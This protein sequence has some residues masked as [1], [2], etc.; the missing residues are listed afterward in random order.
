MEIRLL[1]VPY[2]SGQRNVRMGAGPEHLRAAGLP[3][4]LA[5]SGHAVDVQM[6]EP[7]SMKWQAEVQ[8][9]F[10]LM[11]AVAEQVRA[12]RAEGRFPI[13]LSGNCLAAVG[14]IA[15]LGAPHRCDLDR[16][17]RRFQYPANDHEWFSRRHDSGDRDRPVLEG[18]G[19]I[20]S[21]VSNQS[22][23]SAVVMFGARDLDPGEGPALARY[24]I[25]RLRCEARRST[26]ST[27]VLEPSPDAWNSFTSISIW[28]RS[29]RAKVAPTA[30]AARGG[31][32]SESLRVLL[33]AI[34]ETSAGGGADDS[35][36]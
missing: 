24:Q 36:L 16:C 33:G 22:R 30:I 27:P 14:V 20:A 11:R 34:A 3:E 4:S 32:T 29:I 10:E 28:T 35:E 1:L 25:V 26:K 9:S 23:T 6:I 18:I 13:V 5:A 21:R 8:T 7:A 19:A 31:F 17:P 12:A 2:D 15:G